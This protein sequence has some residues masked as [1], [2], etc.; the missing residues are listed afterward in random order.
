MSTQK[1]DSYKY[2]LSKGNQFLDKDDLFKSPALFHANTMLFDSEDLALDKAEA[3]GLH[4][5][6]VK[7]MRRPVKV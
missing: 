7:V 3:L 5:D 4:L 2:A 6:T 1:A